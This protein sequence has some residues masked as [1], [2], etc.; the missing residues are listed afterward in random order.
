MDHK[1]RRRLRFLGRQEN[2]SRGYV[3]EFIRSTD[4][5]IYDFSLCRSTQSGG[6]TWIHDTTTDLD[7]VVLR[8]AAILYVDVDVDVSDVETDNTSLVYVSGSRTL[9]I[10][11]QFDGNKFV[12][13][14]ATL[15]LAADSDILLDKWS[16]I[17]G[18]LDVQVDFATTTTI[19]VIVVVVIVVD[20]VIVIVSIIVE[21]FR[22]SG[23]HCDVCH[24]C[25]RRIC[26]RFHNHSLS[27][28]STLSSS[29]LFLSSS[30]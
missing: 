24:H 12:A 14:S 11:N 5:V 25:R 2:A 17:W 20:I 22:R 7:R 27:S 18:T 16:F 9:Q 28:L 6:V 8:N 4:L 21:H 23:R 26:H 13:G 1:P 30:S 10:G 3:C 29:S 19:T 15:Q